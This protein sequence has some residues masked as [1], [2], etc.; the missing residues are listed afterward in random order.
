MSA[1]IKIPEKALKDLEKALGKLVQVGKAGSVDDE[2][3]HSIKHEDYDCL[4]QADV[5]SGA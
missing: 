4:S 2:A 3:D 1:D 5:L